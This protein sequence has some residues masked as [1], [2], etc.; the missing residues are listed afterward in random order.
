MTRG[1]LD[2]YEWDPT[3]WDDDRDELSDEAAYD[4]ALRRYAKAQAIEDRDTG[5]TLDKPVWADFVR[6][7]DDE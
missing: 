7:H 6:G 1:H 5:M 2:V 3:C 4:R